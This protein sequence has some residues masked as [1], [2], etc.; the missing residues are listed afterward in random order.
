MEERDVGQRK[1]EKQEEE[2]EEGEEEEEEEESEGEGKSEDGSMRFGSLGVA[3]GGWWSGLRV[4]D[5]G[6]GIG[7]TAREVQQ[8][9]ASRAQGS[10]GGRVKDCGGQIYI[11]GT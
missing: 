5:W 7:L 10:V 2:E 11:L 8:P 9:A 4:A 3:R 1:E 6:L